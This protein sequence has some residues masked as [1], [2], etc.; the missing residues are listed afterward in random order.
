MTRWLALLA[1]LLSIGTVA[2][3]MVLLN[4]LVPWADA[5]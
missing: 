2:G 3:Y 4:A 1:L 5:R